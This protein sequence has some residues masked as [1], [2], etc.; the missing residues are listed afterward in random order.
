MASKNKAP[1][2]APDISVVGDQLQIYPSGYTEASIPS[3]SHDT[4]D[5]NLVEHMSRFRESPLDFLREISLH[6]Q[7]SGWR[8]YDNIIGQP[9]FYSGFSDSMK[10]SVMQTPMLRAKIVELAAKRLT[11]EEDEGSLD[12]T[13]ASYKGVRASRRV[14]IE[15][16]LRDVAERMTDEMICKMESKRFIRG[17][18]YLV[19]ALTTRAY[20][21]GASEFSKKQSG[22]AL[23]IEMFG[24]ESTS[25]VMKCCVF[26]TL[27]K[28]LQEIGNQLFSCLAIDL[29]STTSPYNLSVT[30]LALPSPLSLLVTT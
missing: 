9:V 28:R 19:T 26:E 29:T 3:R 5:R 11:V 1:P 22:G 12:T 20:H 18:Y 24:K 6:I 14:E 4:H 10:A 30:G 7:G 21:Q 15:G 17:A 23:G 25:P 13:S 8:S 27:Q 16:S 2:A